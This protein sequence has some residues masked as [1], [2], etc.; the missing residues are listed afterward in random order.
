MT[1]IITVLPTTVYCSQA[2]SC[3]FI[4]PGGFPSGFFITFASHAG[5]RPAPRINK[6]ALSTDGAF[7]LWICVHFDLTPVDNSEYI[8]IHVNLENA[9]QTT[10]EGIPDK[11]IRYR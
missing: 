4:R 7:L 3:L 9:Y 6:E 8:R 5:E 2:E 11:G 10:P 1:E